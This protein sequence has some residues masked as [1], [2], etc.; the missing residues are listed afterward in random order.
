MFEVQRRFSFLWLLQL[1]DYSAA[2]LVIVTMYTCMTSLILFCLKLETYSIILVNDV[3]DLLVCT[4][5]GSELATEITPAGL[6]QPFSFC[7]AGNIT[8]QKKLVSIIYV[9]RSHVFTP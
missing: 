5:F 8:C 1:R 4:L 2:V 6:K 7:S 3:F 9:I